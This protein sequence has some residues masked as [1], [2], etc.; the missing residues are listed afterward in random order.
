MRVTKYSGNLVAYD[1]DKLK[2]SLR[3]SG[4]ND[5]LVVEVLNH[6]EPYLFDGISTK[7]IYKLA[8]QYLKTK[9]HPQAAK[10]NLRNS[11]MALGPAGF[12]F[13][14]F[15][16]QL[17][18]L[19]GYEVTMNLFLEG[20]CVK[21]EIDLII[22]KNEEITLVE[23]KFHSSPDVKTD[24]KVPM[25]ILSRFND[26][27]KKE[28]I[29]FNEKSKIDTCLIITNNKFTDEA[30]KFG[31]CCNLKMLSWDY[32]AKNSISELIKLYSCYPITCLTTLTIAEKEKLLSIN[33]L[34]IENLI[35][36]S[37]W[38]VK[39]EISTNRIRKILSECHQLNKD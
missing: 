19:M 1:K 8:F 35:N 24:V 28:Y 29:L 25:Y 16:S 37:D 20:N 27:N 33:I 18:V 26:L 6:I 2:Q 39:L 10:Y 23:C 12:Y 17:F 4:A 31:N 22:K 9:S 34:T 36:N 3:K 13:E 21:H 11:L 14:K 7:K 30:L 15:M 38:L 5:A 32:P